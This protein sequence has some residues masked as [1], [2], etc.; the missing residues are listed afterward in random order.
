MLQVL[1]NVTDLRIRAEYSLAL[2]T[3]SIDNVV[4]SANPVRGAESINGGAGA[5][6]LTVDDS[7]D[8]AANTG[9]L[10]ATR[11]T[12]LG[13]GSNGLT[14]GA[15]ETLSV[16]L[17]T[18]ADSFSVQATNA[19]T[20]TTINAG[21]ENDIISVGSLAP[22]TGGTINAIAGALTLNGE[23]GSD[24]LS[25]DDSGDTTANTGTLTATTLAGLGLGPSGLT[26][27]TIES[28]TVNL[29]SGADTLTVTGTG[30]SAVIMGNDGND[31]LNAAASAQAITLHGGNGDDIL[32]S[33]SGNDVL[34]GDAGND[35]LDGG[36]LFD[37]HD[38]GAGVDTVT[39][40]FYSG[41][42]IANLE[43]GVV[44][45]PVGG[46]TDQL[47]SVENLIGSRGND[48]IVGSSA[49][50]V[51][52][53]NLGNDTITAGAGNDTLRGGD[54]DDQISVVIGAGAGSYSIEGGAGTDTLTVD[55]SSDSTANTGTL[56]ATQVTGLGFFGATYSTVEAL[57]VRLGS[58]ANTFTVTSTN[59]GTTTTITGGAA[60]DTLHVQATGGPTTLNAGAGNDVITVGSL[61][62]GTGGTV[63]NIRGALTVN[64]E[65]G[66][67]TVT[68]DD[69]G[70]R[71]NTDV[72]LTATTVTMRSASA[73]TYGTVE[74]LQVNTSSGGDA[75]VLIQSTS[76]TTSTTVRTAVGPHFIMVG[77]QAPNPGGTVNSIAGALTLL[78][79]GSDTLVVDDSGDPTA[80]TG[81]TAGVVT[82]TTVTGLGLGPNGV[83]YS[84]ISN[85]TVQFG[86]AGDTVTLLD[87]SAATTVTGGQGNET[88]R[89]GPVL[90]GTGAPLPEPGL[91]LQGQD[92]AGIHHTTT[93]DGGEGNDVFQA[94]RNLA[95][96]TLRGGL[97]DDT[98]GLNQALDPNATAGGQGHLG[99]AP[100]HI[101][102]GAGTDT[103]TLTGTSLAEVFDLIGTSMTVS[104]DFNRENVSGPGPG[105]SYDET[106]IEGHTANGSGGVDAFAVETAFDVN[107]QPL[108]TS[109]LQQV[110]VH[111]DAGGDFVSVYSNLA[112]I[113]TTVHGN[114]GDDVLRVVRVG[115][116]AGPLHIFGD[117]NPDASADTDRLLVGYNIPGVN[118]TG[119]L[120]ASRLT[121]LGMGPS[122]L[123]YDG[124][125]ETLE[126]DLFD[127]SN[128]FTAPKNFTIQGTNASTATTIHGN[129]GADVFNVQ[130][131]TTPLTINAGAGNDV[132][133]VGSLASA[134]GGTVNAIAGAL[135]IN[136]EA[137]SDS[138]LVDDSGDTTANTGTL[139]ATMLT[140]LGLGAGFTYGTV[141][142]L[143]VNLGFAA[144]GVSNNQLGVNST[145]AGTT[146]TINGG[147][148]NDL[149]T[150]GSG[151]NVNAIA[152]ALTVHGNA[153][154]DILTVD[155][156]GDT[157][158]NTG[159]LTA[160]TLSGL[161]LGAPLTYGTFERLNVNLGAGADSLTVQNASPVPFLFVNAG[162]GADT[163]NI[164][165]LGGSGSPV[166]NAGAGNDVITVGSL[167]PAAG[168]T[169][170]AI[171]AP[172]TINGD[173]GTDVLTLNDSG[174]TMPNTG[175]LSAT[176]LTGLGLG[177][178]GLT[179]NTVET[180]NLNLGGA[181]GTYSLGNQRPTSVFFVQGQSFTPAQVGTLGSAGAPASGSVL[182]TSMSIDYQP[183]TTPLNTLSIYT[184]L[185]TTATAATGID[186][187]A[188]GT[189]I[190]GGTYT[191]SGVALD[192]NT[193]YFAVL[194]APAAIFDGA[195][196][197]Y[198]GG[199]DI[200]DIGANGQ[201]DEGGG[202]FDIGFRATFTVP[203][204]SL[205]IQ[206]T[207]ATTTTVITGSA[208][209][210]V[211]NVRATSGPVT[212]HAGDGNDVFTVGSLAPFRGGTVN[213]I[214]GALTLNGHNG[215]DRLT[216][217]DSGDV[218]ANT[219]NLT[220]TT[221]SG[222]GMGPSGLTYGTMEALTVNLGAGNDTFN[223]ASTA[224]GT[225]T[226][227]NGGP[228]NDTFTGTLTGVIVNPLLAA[229]PAPAISGTADLL[230]DAQ[231]TPVVA[232]AK[233]LWTQALGAEDRRLAALDDVQMMVGNL[234]EDHLGITLGG[235]ILI[236]STAAERG[237]FVDATPSVHEEF[238][239]G[240][241][242]EALVAPSSS[243]AY[244][245]IDLLTVVMHEMGHVLGLDDHDAAPDAHDLMAATLATG[246]RRLV[247]EASPQT[248]IP[249]SQ[250]TVAA[251]DAF[252]SA[253]APATSQP[254]QAL[255]FDE[256]SGA[257]QSQ[258]HAPAS[259]ATHGSLLNV[260]A[261]NTSTRRKPARQSS[262]L[263]DA[264][265]IEWY[266]TL[267][268]QVVSSMVAQNSAVDW[269]IPPSLRTQ[270]TGW[271]QPAGRKRGLSMLS[272]LVKSVLRWGQ[273]K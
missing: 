127:S 68:V 98:F 14:Y 10:T 267:G 28:L 210:D 217:D 194:P 12:G 155:D 1:G 90:D 269:Y 245:Q 195:G 172:L 196:N 192:V 181:A 148:G 179:Y 31:T 7:G 238:T 248:T 266:K 265:V 85:L 27:G 99:N 254:T 24:T 255:V 124:T 213:A 130:A 157:T 132:I 153:G 240:G 225:T 156:S 138:L 220:S 67:D 259:G 180:L 168:G 84:G 116:I 145:T 233:L 60:V 15:V 271:P 223:V 29:G 239:Q 120:T 204:T 13:L 144:I 234:P 47:V 48:I 77:S 16:Q 75:G 64:G 118:G 201:L 173:A 110:N 36:F 41:G 131:L 219:G 100:V 109:P 166:V 218:P 206:G 21:A 230:T 151:G 170:N 38:G 81:P 6:S 159:T 187:L 211:F 184:A 125:T 258:H 176:A 23:A 235:L 261:F 22:A 263:G 164:Q 107:E 73:I 37:T 114:A 251:R 135:T 106:S 79:N 169:V 17:G 113:T 65:A 221:L 182:L 40:D 252:Q 128:N 9:Q 72:T 202:V 199:T 175:T 119:T 270:D 30:G 272:S 3:D 154:P 268:T 93:L 43:T 193:K 165:A 115:R 103:T 203:N 104:V 189:H 246:V 87:T 5:D 171:S 56:T 11:V 78:G 71:N 200:F 134:A 244:G 247:A 273:N 243:P 136:G 224:A 162:D 35:T 46:P 20:A 253:A 232:E 212:I 49:S 158:A 86:A 146:T 250:P 76:A 231:L 108:A 215:T 174:D 163:L 205:T 257:F 52:D 59:A 91:G 161:G 33:G 92:V 241:N 185:P 126:V 229:G 228:G 34:M 61:A 160:T 139:S 207:S 227:L 123:T 226:T 97:G 25:I 70:G 117:E 142:T 66:T 63:A 188:V 121:G 178:F 262:T 95:D 183:G 94:T 102:G 198:T 45:F 147:A 2:D 57:A 133:R 129:D 50:N 149:I 62:P 122:G 19:M 4:L 260:A 209:A 80:S 111:G 186:S 89:V 58:G 150:V 167:A 54:G 88:F 137:G 74:T 8:T 214:A 249:A 208:G 44:G 39:Y 190:G 143:T 222:L 256:A 105:R 83:R 177:L 242:S 216:V 236:D 152:G 191:F 197:T 51:I 42:I 141:E 55:D 237:W 69:S 32:S 26:Y 112:S 18:G 96:L 53:G 140:G 82:A 264:D 101:D